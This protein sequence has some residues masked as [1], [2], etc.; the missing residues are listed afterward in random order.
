MQ[1][2]IFKIY[3]FLIDTS[4]LPKAGTN[5]DNEL[6][7]RAF[8]TVFTILTGIAL[9]SIVYG[10]FKYVISRG[11]PDRIGKAKDIIMYSVIGLIIAFCA[12]GL[13]NLLLK[14][15]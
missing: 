2:F 1:L 12:F 10:G 9:I 13:V 14:A 7:I 3:A 15:L 6:L 8:N 5:G 11:E 4:P